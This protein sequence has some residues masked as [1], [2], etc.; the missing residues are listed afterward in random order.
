MISHLIFVDLY[1]CSI[2][3]Y[4]L[5]HWRNDL[6]IQETITALEY[7]IR[8][9][10]CRSM[11]SHSTVEFLISVIV[12]A[13]LKRYMNEVSDIVLQMNKVRLIHCVIV[14]PLMCSVNVKLTRLSSCMFSLPHVQ[15][16]R[17]LLTSRYWL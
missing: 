6:L 3:N 13:L 12:S 8:M 14:F 2:L 11:I 5:N 1:I 7:L 16:F 15:L 9:G 4:A 10:C 17:H